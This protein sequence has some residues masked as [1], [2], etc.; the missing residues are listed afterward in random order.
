MAT[1]LAGVEIGRSGAATRDGCA[2]SVTA[3]VSERL[4]VAAAGRVVG[5]EGVA[6]AAVV[7]T[8]LAAVVLLEEVTVDADAV[9]AEEQDAEGEIYVGSESG[10]KAELSSGLCMKTPGARRPER[11]RA[12][13]GL[14]VRTEHRIRMVTG[15]G[16]GRGWLSVTEGEGVLVASHT[17]GIGK[18]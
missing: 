15:F 12:E 1:R 17:R 3:E 9:A 13:Q 5:V 11:G 18:R 2:K 6:E 8:M 4:P 10:R 16:D 14:Q 7:P